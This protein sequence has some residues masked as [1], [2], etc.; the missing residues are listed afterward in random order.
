MVWVPALESECGTVASPP[1]QT[2]SSS[3]NMHTQY[4]QARARTLIKWPIFPRPRLQK[5]Y[6]FNFIRELRRPL[7]DRGVVVQIFIFEVVIFCLPILIDSTISSDQNFDQAFIKLHT[8]INIREKQI[9]DIIQ[10]FSYTKIMYFINFKFYYLKFN[11]YITKSILVGEL[12]HFF[13][14][15]NTDQFFYY[16]I[17]YNST[18]LN[19]YII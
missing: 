8:S 16:S 9:F 1:P 12:L 3:Q 7:P 2:L 10:R 4:T 15:N 5:N 6:I 17:L 13:F 18:L 11:A 19:T 14:L